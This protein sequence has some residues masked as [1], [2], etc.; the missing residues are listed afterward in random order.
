MKMVLDSSV[1]FG[2]HRCDGELFTAWSVAE[3]LKDL[4]SKVRFDLLRESGLEVLDPETAYVTRAREASVAAGEE[5]ALSRADT[6]VLALA[7][8]LGAA[9]VTDDYALQNVA[10][11]LGVTVIPL[12]QKGTSGI[13]WKYRCTGCGRY[14][15]GP[16]ECPVCGSPVKRRI[17]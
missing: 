1:F 7:V 16:G 10:R 3:E 2:D 14:H 11:K 15:K 5:E 8:Q 6:D 17:K 13:R 4:A 12:R 9:V